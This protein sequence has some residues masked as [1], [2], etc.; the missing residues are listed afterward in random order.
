MLQYTDETIKKNSKYK[1]M[2]FGQ[3]V[4]KFILTELDYVDQ[5]NKS[6]LNIKS[7]LFLLNIAKSISSIQLYHECWSAIHN[8]HDTN[9]LL[10][11]NI[12]YRIL[13]RL[14]NNNCSCEQSGWTIFNGLIN[15]DVQNF[16][17][18]Q[19][20]KLFWFQ[21][22]NYVNLKLNKQIYIDYS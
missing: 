8:M 20:K 11:L 21:F 5:L 1:T 17:K 16:F 13:E 2:N 14:T 22:H 6:N 19:N 18:I 10:Q 12:F 3:H 9:A 15:D 7:K 4:E